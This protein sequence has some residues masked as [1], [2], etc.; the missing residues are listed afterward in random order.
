M[1]REQVMFDLVRRE[2]VKPL[3]GR[4]CD[5]ELTDAELEKIRDK[6]EAAEGKCVVTIVHEQ[7]SSF[8]PL[9]P[10]ARIVVEDEAA[11]RSHAPDEMIP[12]VDKFDPTLVCLTQYVQ[13]PIGHIYMTVCPLPWAKEDDA[14]DH[15]QSLFRELPP[16]CQ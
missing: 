2:I 15:M 10:E 4:V 1:N 8:P 5:A 12:Y 7:S 9:E 14:R 13:L 6:I 16:R 11:Y 3:G